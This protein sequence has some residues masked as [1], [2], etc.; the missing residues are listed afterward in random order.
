MEIQK[1]SADG[2]QCF[3]FRSRWICQQTWNSKQKSNAIYVYIQNMPGIDQCEKFKIQKK[4]EIQ[5][6]KLCT[7]K[8]YKEAIIRVLIG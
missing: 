1:G 3:H 6:S 2:N 4:F 5:K 7:M 8:E